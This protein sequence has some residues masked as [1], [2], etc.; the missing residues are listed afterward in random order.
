M[1][2]RQGNDQY[3]TPPNEDGELYIDQLL[4]VTN[5]IKTA[6][7]RVSLDLQEA[8][9]S[10]ILRKFSKNPLAKP[11]FTVGERNQGGGGAGRERRR[12]TKYHK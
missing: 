5:E 7:R 11:K 12:K 6:N 4:R 9:A 3:K 8:A 2:Y 1:D 10:P